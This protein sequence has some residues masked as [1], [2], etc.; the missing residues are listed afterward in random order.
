MKRER[1]MKTNRGFT[2]VEMLVS[3]SIMMVAIVAT[4][5]ILVEGQRFTRNAEEVSNSNDN[6]R[7]AG[8]LIASALRV[9]GMGGAL[10]VWI[11]NAGTPRLISP[12]FGTDA[13]ATEGNT[14]DI[15]M[16]LADRRG[17]K[18]NNCALN[19][20]GGVT[21]VQGGVGLLNVNCTR[22]LLPAGLANP[23]LLLVANFANP[24]S[25]LTQ[26][27]PVT[28]SDGTVV[29]TIDYGE[30]AVSGF[31]PRGFQQG[32]SAYGAS[33][34]RFF[35]HRDS[36]GSA[37]YRETGRLSGATPPAFVPASVARTLVQ[38]DIEDLQLAYG[39]DPSGTNQPDQY[40]F[41]NGF[42]DTFASALRSVRVSVV[43]IHN[44]QLKRGDMT[45]MTSYKPIS[46]IENHDQTLA[47]NDA[48]R[49]SLY[50]RR[51]EL[52]NLSP[53]TL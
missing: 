33:V 13:I 37:L 28:A 48:Y 51:V 20:G 45:S 42:P 47:P 52:P 35:V 32:D 24:A 6:A 19:S 1:A 29:G 10:G 49:R 8:E 12:I 30:S 18:D 23:P 46:P 44:R 5:M 41:S 4:A 53:G 38:P 11:N 39:V 25:L 31:P 22:S 7:V 43:A 26:P 36:S 14:D 17:F 21:L 9:A 3:M 34:V 16:I 40:V 27:R 50:T 15:W 2:L